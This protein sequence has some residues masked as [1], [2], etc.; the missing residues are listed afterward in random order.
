MSLA[1]A[2]FMHVLFACRLRMIF[3]VSCVILV[4]MAS[5]SSISGFT[6]RPLHLLRGYFIIISLVVLSRYLAGTLVF[7]NVKPRILDELFPELRCRY[8]RFSRQSSAVI[9]S[10]PL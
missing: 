10:R 3:S 8:I 1:Y 4:H 2:A 6:G 7:L 5:L 9:L